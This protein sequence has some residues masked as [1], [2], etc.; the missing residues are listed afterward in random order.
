M[1]RRPCCNQFET[2][3]WDPYDDAAAF[4]DHL[5]RC[6][7]CRTI[8]AAHLRVA[9]AIG[10][11]NENATPPRE[12]QDRVLEK[13]A[14]IEAAGDRSSADRVALVP[15]APQSQTGQRLRRVSG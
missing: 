12:W 8:Q 11:M 9:R 4:T 10:L 2:E 7:D 6:A 5:K 15:A 14:D 3:K 1:T 13:I